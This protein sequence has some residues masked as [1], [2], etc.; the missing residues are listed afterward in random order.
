[1][2]MFWNVPS[3]ITAI[4]FFFNVKSG[5][6]APEWSM[7]KILLRYNPLEY[8]LQNILFHVISSYVTGVDV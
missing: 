2:K 6:Y 4:T 5:Y 8:Q 7:V 3:L 1:M